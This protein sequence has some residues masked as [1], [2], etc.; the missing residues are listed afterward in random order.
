MSTT[1]AQKQLSEADHLWINA[2]LM[3]FEGTESY[4]TL[5][6]AIIASKNGRIS[7]IGSMTEDLLDTL[8]EQ[9][10]PQANKI[11]DLQGKWLSPGLI[12]CHTHLVYGGNRSQEFEQRLTG[13]SYEEIARQGGGILSTV[14][15]TRKATHKQLEASALKRIEHLLN[16][17]VTTLEIKSGYGLD[18]ETEIKMLQVARSIAEKIPANVTTTFLGAHALPP[19]YKDRA[20]DYI[21]LICE[22][23]L[24]KVKA[25]NLADAV[26]AFCENIGFSPA[27]VKRL[28]EHASSMGLALKL[29]AEQLTDQQGTQLAASFSALSVDHL[30][31]VSEQG[32]KTIAD[33]GTVAVLLPAAFYYLREKQLPPIQWLREYKVPI[34]L[35]TDANPGSAP[36][37]SLLLVTNMACTLFQ[38]TPEE[39]LKGVTINAAKAL[40]MDQKIGS[41]AV[42]KQADFAIWD[43][44]APCDIPYAFGHNPCVAVVKDG[45][46]VLDKLSS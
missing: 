41:L 23:M 43:I 5:N 25:E 1:D 21:T 44:D 46:L 32:V 7:Y 24:P 45:E 35:A 27:Q 14:K 20:D 42:G 34:A 16:E 2:N 40:G 22:E 26:D 6:N 9:S 15:A 4:G 18:T 29:H 12:D 11:T 33:S 8:A 31:Y 39:A 36:C 38:M 17:G 3:T 30:E 10:N 19:E 28:F 13:V 37:T